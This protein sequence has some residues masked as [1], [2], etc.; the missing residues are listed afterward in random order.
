MSHHMA[1]KS[2]MNGTG[3][4]ILLRQTNIRQNDSRELKKFKNKLTNIIWDFEIADQTHRK[5]NVIAKCR[6]KK[7]MILQNFNEK[8]EIGQIQR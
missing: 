4:I 5:P 2:L 8:R 3:N 1:Q 7:K 6:R